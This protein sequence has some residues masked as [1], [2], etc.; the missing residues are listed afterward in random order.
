MAVVQKRTRYELV[1]DLS[2]INHLRSLRDLVRNFSRY[3]IF[4]VTVPTAYGLAD[5]GYKAL[6]CEEI[7]PE[8]EEW[9]IGFMFRIG[10]EKQAIWH[11][12]VCVDYVLIDPSSR[13]T[14]NKISNCVRL[15][16][17]FA[18]KHLKA[19]C[20]DLLINLDSQL[21][22]AVKQHVLAALINEGMEMAKDGKSCAKRLRSIDAETGKDRVV[23][24]LPR[25]EKSQV[26]GMRPMVQSTIKAQKTKIGETI[27][28]VGRIKPGSQQHRAILAFCAR[29]PNWMEPPIT[30]RTSYMQTL[31][32]NQPGD[33]RRY[34]ASLIEDAHF[35]V[36]VDA[37]GRISSFM[38]FVVGYSAPALMSADGGGWS[39]PGSY[40]SPERTLF[41]PAVVCK[42][43]GHGVWT[44]DGFQQALSLWK[45]LFTVLAERGNAGKF[46]IAGAQVDE[47][48][49][50]SHLLDALGFARK[51]SFSN[52]PYH[53]KNTALYAR[54]LR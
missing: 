31:F 46:E 52:L 26:K 27:R 54:S 1:S 39:D 9:K 50:H 5:S 4:D 40:V 6:V 37:K 18:L 15:I 20:V 17:Q 19:S 2:K 48:G 13:V 41:V 35:I 29:H 42:S 12:V 49:L 24:P 34:V 28:F 32:T 21:N 33:V 14:F 38:A 51:A 8:G 30:E 25:V 16:S 36:S 3:H 10:R 23:L 53:S 22:P 45:M 44:K 47:G 43:R 7:S 11:T